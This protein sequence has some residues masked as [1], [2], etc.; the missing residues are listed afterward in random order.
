MITLWHY[1]VTFFLVN[2]EIKANLEGKTKT[3]DMFLEVNSLVLKTKY[4]PSPA[5][6]RRGIKGVVKISG[7]FFIIS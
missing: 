2:M 5:C 7:S 3:K 1:E 4:L 6:F